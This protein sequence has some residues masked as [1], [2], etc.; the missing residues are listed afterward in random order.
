MWPFKKREPRRYVMLVLHDGDIRITE[1]FPTQSGWIVRWINSEIAWSILK[2]DGS[3]IGTSIVRSWFKHSGWPTPC[4][5]AIGR[6]NLNTY[7]RFKMKPRGVD[8]ARKYW[9]CAGG[10]PNAA[11]AWD[12][13]DVECKVQFHEL[14][15][16]FGGTHM[17]H[18]T[19]GSPIYDLFVEP[20]PR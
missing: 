12:Q 16:M 8:L 20:L 13:P 4:S 7:V 11:F 14:F 5:A 18:D 19:D 2:D 9:E 17:R 10:I 15:R 3:T 6:L 1:A